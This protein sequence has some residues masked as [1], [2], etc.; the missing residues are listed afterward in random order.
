MGGVLT[1]VWSK[2]NICDYC[3]GNDNPISF[4]IKNIYEDGHEEIISYGFSI[5]KDSGEIIFFVEDLHSK[6]KEILF[7]R[8]IDYCPF[9]GQKLKKG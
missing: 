4:P 5:Q 9:C 7:K 1:L 2:N 6:N 3:D 8:E